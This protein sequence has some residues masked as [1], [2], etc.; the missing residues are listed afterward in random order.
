VGV[1]GIFARYAPSVEASAE[2]TQNFKFG[3]VIAL[4][5]EAG[6]G[7]QRAVDKLELTHIKINLHKKWGKLPHCH[8]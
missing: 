7:A 8:I 2:T 6:N 4:H 1:S 3:S 5:H